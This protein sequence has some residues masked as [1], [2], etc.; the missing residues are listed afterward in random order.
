MENYAKL[1]TQEKRMVNRLMRALTNGNVQ[2]LQSICR[3]ISRNTATD[4]V[5]RKPSGYILFYKENYQTK[6]NEMPMASIGAIAKVLGKQWNS[7]TSEVKT[8]YKTRA[9]GESGAVTHKVE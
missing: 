1:G 3:N 9:A 8:S 5:Q 4:R 2:S 6:R 7:L